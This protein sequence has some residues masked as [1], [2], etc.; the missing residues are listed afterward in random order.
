MLNEFVKI[1]L[2]GLAV[3]AVRAFVAHQRTKAPEWYVDVGCV[4]ALEAHFPVDRTRMFLRSFF[5]EYAEYTLRSANRDSEIYYR[6]NLEITHISTGREVR[7]HEVPLSV[8]VEYQ[9]VGETTH[10]KISY[11]TNEGVRLT[12]A[13]VDFV[14]AQAGIEFDSA[15]AGLSAEAQRFHHAR[16][17]R[18]EQTR[19]PFGGGG[20]SNQAPAPAGG[21]E[22]DLAV[23]GLKPPSNWTAIQA[24]YRDACLK[25]HPDKQVNIPKHLIDLAVVRFKE[26]TAAYQ[27]L[28][29]RFG[30]G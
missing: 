14:R 28:K 29:G 23:L 12:Q 24:A 8:L 16:R 18:E 10:V 4:K 6:G 1:A 21:L 9:T 26:I 19:R 2:R 22:A 25:F 11:L 13:G 20:Q 17:K 5:G 15:L 3:G 30:N 7:W 27:R